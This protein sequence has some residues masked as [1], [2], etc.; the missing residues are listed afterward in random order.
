MFQIIK[1]GAVLAR[2]E[3]PNYIK[4]HENGCFVLCDEAEAEGIAH[5]GEVYSLLGRAELDGRDPVALKEVDTGDELRRIDDLNDTARAVSL[6]A[7]SNMGVDAD[8]AELAAA[9]GNL[10]DAAEVEI[11]TEPTGDWKGGEWVSEDDERTHDKV[12]YICRQRHYTQAH[13]P[14]DTIPALWKTKGDGAGTKD[15]PIT[16]AK[17]M[18]YQYGLYY[19]D[20]E[21][22]GIYLC[23]RPGEEDGGKVVLQYLPHELIGHYFAAAEV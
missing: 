7:L 1:D 13:Y 10:L 9:Q 19:L 5:A 4:L 6:L 15:D 22:A 23:T 21:D 20:P 8:P 14:P 16:A 2:T 18:E 11:T 12:T 17:G 3:N